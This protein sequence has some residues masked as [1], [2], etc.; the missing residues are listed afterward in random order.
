MKKGKKTAA[1]RMEGASIYDV[2]KEAKVSV[3]TVS[4]VFND[5][6]HV[7]QRMRQRVFAAARAAGYTPRL[8][9]KPRVIAAMRRSQAPSFWCRSERRP[10]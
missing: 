4:R 8:V 3:V 6:P 1:A 10:S 2:A 7:S 5:Y 9:T